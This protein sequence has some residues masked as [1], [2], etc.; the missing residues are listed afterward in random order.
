MK[1]WILDKYNGGQSEFEVVHTSK[2]LYD[3][4]HL[5]TSIDGV[6]RYSSIKL[7]DF[8]YNPKYG[9]AKAIWGEDMVCSDTGNSG[10]DECDCKNYDKCVGEISKYWYFL[11]QI[12]LFEDPEK[13]LEMIKNKLK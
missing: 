11:K 7:Y 1:Q 3:L 10:C 8:I 5:Y 6:E 4:K 2:S 9:F 13:Y 12:V